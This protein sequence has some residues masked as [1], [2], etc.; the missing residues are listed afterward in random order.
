MIKS[1][2]VAA[3][4]IDSRSSSRTIKAPS[5]LKMTVRERWYAPKCVTPGVTA[6][7]HSISISHISVIYRSYIGHISVIYQSYI[8]H[9][10]RHKSM[11]KC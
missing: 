7:G 2:K 8:S 10:N 1:E 9:I 11:T 3:V 4:S 6:R 5:E